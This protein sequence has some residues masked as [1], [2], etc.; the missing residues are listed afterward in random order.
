[1]PLEQLKKKKKKQESLWRY[2]TEHVDLMLWQY[3][4]GI[5]EAL[6]HV[7]HL[8]GDYPP[9]DRINAL[10]NT[11]YKYLRD[12]FRI[13]PSFHIEFVIEYDQLTLKKKP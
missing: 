3:G 1:M 10:C 11:R 9:L 4:C 2:L 5:L 7:H 13:A 12:T 6:D 8:Q